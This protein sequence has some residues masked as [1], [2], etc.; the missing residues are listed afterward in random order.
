MNNM[1]TGRRKVGLWLIGA[2][3][4]IATCVALGLSA[5]RRG[6]IDSTGLVT[7]LPEFQKLGLVPWGDW[8]LGGHEIRS[9][10]LLDEA[11][12]FARTNR[13]FDSEFVES[14][15]SELEDVETRIRPGTVS[16]AS[17]MITGLTGP[18]V[19][20]NESPGEA[21]TRIRN[22]LESFRRKN[23][24]DHVVVVNVASTEPP[25]D[26]EKFP[27]RYDE[28]EAQLQRSPEGW[29]PPSALYA[30]AAMQAGC[31][32]VNFTPSLGCNLPALDELARLQKVAYMGC[33]GKTG[34]TLLKTVLAPMFRARNLRVL[35]WV[36]HNIFGNLDG[37]IL[38]T[39]SHKQSKVATK[40]RVLAEILGYKPAT[41]VTIEYL[42]DLGD[43]KTAWDH[44]HFSGFLGVPMVLQVI[45]QGCDSILAAPLVLDLARL[46]ERAVRSGHVGLM[47]FLA[48]F[49]KSPHGTKEHDFGKQFAQLMSWV[50]G[51]IAGGG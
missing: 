3:G 33:D 50:D 4:G 11:Q 40:D 39:P 26:A 10:H 42:E 20:K 17:P 24:L 18:E 32:Y 27:T 16:G 19:P 6:L 23:E 1:V 25:V 8:V 47:P 31:S 7:A 29:L 2:R 36:G 28:F 48:C 13:T 35:S 14:L 15:R 51:L 34:E 49:F 45:W 46:T 12:D 41:V 21:V 37:K 5:L 43:W 38:D 44:V 30:I 9:T 22:D